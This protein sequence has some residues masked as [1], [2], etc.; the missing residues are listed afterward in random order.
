MV[1]MAPTVLISIIAIVLIIITIGGN[2]MVILTFNYGD[3]NTSTTLKCFYTSL[4]VA[5]LIIGIFSLPLFSVFVIFGHWPFNRHLC[6]AWLAVDYFACNASVWNLM[7]IAI[8]R[9][10][11]ATKPLSHLVN[12]TSK[13]AM[14]MIGI[15]WG[16]S[17]I[18][19]V[20]PIITWKYIFNERQ[21]QEG[22]C[23]IG[24]LQHNLF[25]SIL[26]STLSF[27]LPAFVICILYKG[28]LKAKRGSIKRLK[29]TESSVVFLGKT[30]A[31]FCQISLRQKGFR[32]LSSLILVFLISWIPYSVLSILK[33]ILEPKTIPQS[34]WDIS[35]GLMYINSTINPFCYA[36]TTPSFRKACMELINKRIFWHRRNLKMDNES[37]PLQNTV[38]GSEEL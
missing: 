17:F 22:E 29:R 16:I 35:Y 32:V 13:K 4:A 21:I 3:M 11:G 5:D 1:D 14:I 31:K 23:Y 28:I 18:I 37:I 12:R 2:L 10:Q 33:V 36:M 38:S 15:A 8:D 30:P 19:W 26:A 6:E 25:L 34:I 27:Y 7:M 24:F 9:Y 20:I